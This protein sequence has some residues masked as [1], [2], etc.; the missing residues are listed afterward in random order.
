MAAG[1]S[2]MNCFAERSYKAIALFKRAQKRNNVVSRLCE[3]ACRPKNRG[4]QWHIHLCV[5]ARSAMLAWWDYACRVT[6]RGCATAKLKLFQAWNRTAVCFLG[7]GEVGCITA[8]LSFSVTL[9]K[10]IHYVLQKWIKGGT[11]GIEGKGEMWITARGDDGDKM[12][13]AKSTVMNI[14]MLITATK[15]SGNRGSVRLLRGGKGGRGGETQADVSQ[16]DNVREGKPRLYRVS[17]KAESEQGQ[18]EQEVCPRARTAADEKNPHRRRGT[19][20]ITR[21]NT[22]VAGEEKI[23]HF[24]F[25]LHIFLPRR[26]K[27]PVWNIWILF[28]TCIFLNLT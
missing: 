24:S 15:L 12:K 17:L 8:S 25:I 28:Q 2:G 27:G 13:G 14:Y 7:F 5:R 21:H 23:C 19:W 18:R 1:F 20:T 16:V 10:K 3:L 4:R 6:L 26:T 11:W 22:E 9:W